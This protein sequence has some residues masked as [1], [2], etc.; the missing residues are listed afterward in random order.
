MTT[1]RVTWTIDLDAD[2]PEDAAA[3]A[4]AI[5]RDPQS[6]A[7]VFDVV[8]LT[9]GGLT[10]GKSASVDLCAHPECQ[11]GGNGWLACRFAQ[12]SSQPKAAGCIQTSCRFCG[13]DIENLAPYRRGEWRDRGNEPACHSGEN[14][15][16]PHAPVRR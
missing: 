13:L 9:N 2:R 12:V 6:I 11:R 8:E 4:Q 5:Q 7:T 14:T 16:K 15:G 3:C 10:K 1:Y